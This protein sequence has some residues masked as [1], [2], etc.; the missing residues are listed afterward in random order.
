MKKLNALIALFA[1]VF[2]LNVFADATEV[3]PYMRDAVI[4]VTLKNG[5]VYKFSGNTHA[6]V[7]RASSNK[8][9]P[10]EIVIVEKEKVVE[11]ASKQ[12]CEDAGYK[13]PKLN[14]VK[15]ML[16]AGPDGL[17]TERHQSSV[18]VKSSVGAVGGLGYDRLIDKDI[19]VGGQI[20]TNGTC[21]LGVGL[22]F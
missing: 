15:V 21:T 17:E 1:I 10:A 16:G 14:R 2:S 7:T 9:K 22:D 8:K 6:V 20:M 12:T 19:S 11:K 13:E 18:T 5:K 3:P 4:T